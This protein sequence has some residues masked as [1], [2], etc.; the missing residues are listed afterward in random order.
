MARLL[1]SASR[2]SSSSCSRCS[3][4]LASAWRARRTRCS[5]YLIRRTWSCSHAAISCSTSPPACAST[6]V[7]E[8]YPPVSRSCCALTA[9]TMVA[10]RS[11]VS[12]RP[13]MGSSSDGSGPCWWY[14]V[15]PTLR[16]WRSLVTGSP[17]VHI[18]FGGV[19]VAT[20][21]FGEHVGPGHARGGTD[22]FRQPRLVVSSV[23]GCEAALLDVQVDGA[24]P[25]WLDACFVASGRADSEL[26]EHGMGEALQLPS[27]VSSGCIGA[28]DRK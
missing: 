28:L 23:P 8:S 4:L 6:S 13:M 20:G 15:R 21:P 19:G 24:E 27:L 9:A 3:H 25:W 10:A 5:A 12:T 22:R 11:G 18:G 14:R 2:A 26:G 16:P 17:A 1:R 7:R